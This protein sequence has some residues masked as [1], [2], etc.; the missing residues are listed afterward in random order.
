MASDAESPPHPDSV[1]RSATQS[2]PAT[3]ADGA[4]RRPCTARLRRERA[5]AVGELEALGG[6][7][8]LLGMI[9]TSL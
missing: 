8:G 2:P 4:L 6:V 9:I 5:C 7:A 1:I 3:T